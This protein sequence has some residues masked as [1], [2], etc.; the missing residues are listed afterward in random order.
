MRRLFV[1]FINAFLGVAEFHEIVLLIMK[2]NFPNDENL[3]DI[4]MLMFEENNDLVIWLNIL[5]SFQ[6]LFYYNMMEVEG[7]MEMDNWNNKAKRVVDEIFTEV[8]FEKMEGRGVIKR[9]EEIENM[10]GNDG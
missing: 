1:M 8:I 4:L 10:Q 5:K 3:A 7:M 6:S 2:F 9:L